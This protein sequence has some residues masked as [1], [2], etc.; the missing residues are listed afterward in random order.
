MLGAVLVS[1]IAFV[2]GLR[3]GFCACLLAG[4]VLMSPAPAHAKN[5]ATTDVDA[6]GQKEFAKY[7]R[8]VVLHPADAGA[9]V[10]L[11][12]LLYSYH[13]AG[14]AVTRW[15]QALAID[16]TLAITHWSLGVVYA[17]RGDV[18]AAEAE[19]LTALQLDPRHV[20]A[21]TNLAVIYRDRG[22]LAA[23]KAEYREILKIR[24]D[25]IFVHDQLGQTLAK[26][27]NWT[28]ALAEYRTELARKENTGLATALTRIDLANALIATGDLEAAEKEIG[29]AN[30]FLNERIEMH[31]VPRW[32]PSARTVAYAALA[33][34]R[35]RA[36]QERPREAIAA[37]AEVCSNN[38][39]L[40]E[41]VEVEPDF[42]TL[43]ETEDY[44]RLATDVRAQVKQSLTARFR[45]TVR[46]IEI[47]GDRKA[48]VALMEA[49]AK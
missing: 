43:R 22:E 19:Y 2:S 4:L 42:A 41:D 6:S 31:G 46:R 35:I 10:K 28:E 14:D 49:D 11:G 25:E 45:G 34:A 37:L 17:E 5:P 32:V 30:E 18:K 7:E 13:R 48:T 38:P 47:L 24:P 33:M 39:G 1:P 21:R 20:A 16:D 3:Q 23:A 12:D 27:K 29:K 44:R 40:L 9:L 15:K 36:R 8:L 26:E